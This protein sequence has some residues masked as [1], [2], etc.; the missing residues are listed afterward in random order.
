MPIGSMEV[1]NL[2]T[3]LMAQGR[4]KTMRHSLTFMLRP[5]PQD[6]EKA[7]TH[8]VQVKSGEEWI[9]VGDAWTNTIKTGES[10]GRKMFSIRL[11]DP[12]LPEWMENISAFPLNTVDE[13]GADEYELVRNRQRQDGQQ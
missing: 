13:D 2:E 7:P 4:I 11:T 12:D 5:V 1:K 9:D 8:V 10:Q 3:G 6:R